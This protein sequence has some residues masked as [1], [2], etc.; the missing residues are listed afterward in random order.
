MCLRVIVC[1]CGMSW[2]WLVPAAI[3]ADQGARSV[4]HLTNGGFLPGEL[5]ALP[6]H[7]SFH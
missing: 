1:I 3:A 2:F 4:L 7:S 6:G 5:R